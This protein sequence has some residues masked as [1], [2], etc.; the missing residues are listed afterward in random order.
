LD[1]TVKIIG[2]DKL[3]EKEVYPRLKKAIPFIIAG[4]AVSGQCFKLS[5]VIIR[6]PLT[7]ISGKGL[8]NVILKGR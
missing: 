8:S 5:W 6:W 3:L 2:Q 1:E 4:H 7:G